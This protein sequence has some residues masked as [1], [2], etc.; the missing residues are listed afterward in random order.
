MTG[1]NYSV[2]IIIILSRFLSGRSPTMQISD[3]ELWQRYTP[4]AQWYCP[5]FWETAS[6]FRTCSKR[7]W[8][9]QEEVG[10]GSKRPPASF[11]YFRVWVHKRRGGEW[12]GNGV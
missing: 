12:G 4:W 6:S 1:V 10:T 8:S 11:H 5:R 7:Q 2:D 9:S 3:V